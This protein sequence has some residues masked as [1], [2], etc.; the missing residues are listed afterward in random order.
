MHSPVHLCE[1]ENHSR[2]LL[3]V[4]RTARSISTPRQHN[5]IISTDRE[6]FI[7]HT[8]RIRVTFGGV[9]SQKNTRWNAH[10]REIDL[11]ADVWNALT[12]ILWRHR[13]NNLFVTFLHL[14]NLPQNSCKQP[15]KWNTS[16][17]DGSRMAEVSHA[18]TTWFQHY[19]WI[20][21]MIHRFD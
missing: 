21:R 15:Q 11:S 6:S 9:F 3:I 1:N 7:L 5:T 13:R 20:L 8:H 4:S 14:L 12:Q 2:W 19:F 10:I 18:I 17:A 16:S